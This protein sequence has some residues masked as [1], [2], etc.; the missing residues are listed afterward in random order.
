MKAE[1]LEDWSLT[2]VGFR[3]VEGM[4]VVFQVTGS[5]ERKLSAQRGRE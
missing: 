4:I 3:R 2:A 1:V 5:K